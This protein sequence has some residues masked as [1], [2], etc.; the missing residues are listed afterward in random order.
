MDNSNTSSQ[1]T[2]WN[3]IILFVVLEWLGS[4]PFILHPDG[5][6]RE[7][8]PLFL[9]L[10]NIIPVFLLW[11]RV[12]GNRA[13][14][15]ISW[16]QFCRESLGLSIRTEHT[17]YKQYSTV[18]LWCVGL[19]TTIILANQLIGHIHIAMDET[20]WQ[21]QGFQQWLDITFQR[22]ATEKQIIIPALP[23][24]PSTFAL[25]VIGGSLLLPWITWVLLLPEE[26]IWRGWL[27]PELEKTYEKKHSIYLSSTLYTIAMFPISWIQYHSISYTLALFFL[28]WI[29]GWYRL[30]GSLVLS[31]FL[32]AILFSTYP[33]HIILQGYNDPIGNYT[34]YFGWDGWIGVWC[35]FLWHLYLLFCGKE[36][37]QNT[38]KS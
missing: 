32:F 12:F 25:Y 14:K 38:T 16:T 29:L 9:L 5:M 31:S 22:F 34:A 33:W 15:E 30:H 20:F 6:N 28:S 37:R 10:S 7:N 24:Y 8:A 21:F 4:V 17:G 19:S 13:K 11:Q 23:M 18:F 26:I 2:Q 36:V 3:T 35:L 1:I 27:L